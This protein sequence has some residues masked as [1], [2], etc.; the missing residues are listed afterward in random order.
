MVLREL[1]IKLGL[2]PDEASFATGFSTVEL[3]KKG[4]EELKEI[5]QKVK[6]FLIEQVE[7]TVEAGKEATLLSQRLGITAK[8][9]QELGYVGKLADVTLEEMTHAMRELAKHG[10]KDL[11]EGLLRVAE[12]ASRMPEGGAKIAYVQ[13]QLGRFG[14]R[15]I[16]VLNQGREG[17]KKLM[18]EAETLGVVMDKDALAATERYRYATVRLHGALDGL[19][20]SVF[21]PLLTLLAKITDAITKVV[22]AIAAW[23]KSSPHL[24]ENILRVVRIV[25]VLTPGLL[26]LYIAFKAL[27]AIIGYV[28][29]HFQQIEAWV[30]KYRAAITALAV[31]L[32]L[33]LVPMVLIGLAIDDLITF[34]EGGDSLIGRALHKWLGPFKD[35]HEALKLIWEK[36]KTDM[37][38]AFHF[39]VDEVKAI[40]LGLWTEIKA[41]AIGVFAEIG[42]AIKKIPGVEFLMN[43]I[44]AATTTAA[45]GGNVADVVG[46]YVTGGAS[47]PAAA[48]AVKGSTSSKSSV[49]INHLE[50]KSSHGESAE[51]I[52]GKI[53][54]AIQDHDDRANRDAAAAAGS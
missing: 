2:K 54:K 27:G 25:V 48:A 20:N 35:L 16:P 36:I 21:V 28:S 37:A 52:A 45:N 51:D 24:F 43:H 53:P 4:L 38:T 50:V 18:E 26:A 5:A 29:D 6:R 47:S 14:G 31:A 30:W 23:V 42:A 22:V 33:P 39:A 17:V 12:T 1:F 41:G 15:L 40:F 8:A 11:Q 49:V 46:S 3:L 7:A 32:F 34:F 19:R 9:A 10:V 44:A 13:Q